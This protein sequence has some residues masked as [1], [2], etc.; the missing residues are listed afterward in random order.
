MERGGLPEAAVGGERTARVAADQPQPPRS[1]VVLTAG[2]M[3][4]QFRAGLCHVGTEDTAVVGTI[5]TFVGRSEF[6]ASAGVHRQK[7]SRVGFGTV[8]TS[9]LAM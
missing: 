9:E 5:E 6:I 2:S 8:A 3:P 7:G 4:M 1:T